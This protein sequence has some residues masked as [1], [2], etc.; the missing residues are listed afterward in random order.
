M[1]GI[2]GW[3]RPILQQQLQA[4][5]FRHQVVGNDEIGRLDADA[6][7]SFDAVGR[8]FDLQLRSLF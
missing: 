2:S 6:F 5:H 7:Q 3:S 4:V 8:V 1:T